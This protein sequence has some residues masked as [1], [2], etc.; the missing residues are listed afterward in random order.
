MLNPKH[1]WLMQ[2]DIQSAKGVLH[3]KLPTCAGKLQINLV[4]MD[5]Y[6]NSKHHAA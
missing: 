4:D 2:P 1:F 3:C 6:Q 5:S